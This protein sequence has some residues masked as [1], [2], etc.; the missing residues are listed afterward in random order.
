VNS[1]KSSHREHVSDSEVED[2]DTVAGMPASFADNA[3][4]QKLH[5]DTGSKN[6]MSLCG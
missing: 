2:K 4:H 3:A 5:H 1:A 6:E